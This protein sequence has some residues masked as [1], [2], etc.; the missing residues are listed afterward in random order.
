MHQ[1]RATALLSYLVSDQRHVTFVEST[2]G[3]LEENGM[4]FLARRYGLGGALALCGL[5][6]ALYAWRRIVAFL[7]P[8]ETGPVA[9]EVALAYEP[10]AGFTALLRRS[11]G[12]AAVLP[13]CVEEWRKGR[14]AGG[15]RTA[16][17]R[18][19]AAWQARDP[20][21]PLAS[22]YNDLARALKPR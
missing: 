4:G 9:G 1:E 8:Q 11:L 15:N 12:A 5:L 13:A 2:L 3:V 17:A 7:P 6:G 16:D 18:L 14:R 20:R 10:A 19:E 21:Q 22:T